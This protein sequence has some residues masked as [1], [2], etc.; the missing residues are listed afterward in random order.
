MQENNSIFD[1]LS[2]FDMFGPQIRLTYFGNTRFST[3]LGGLC[4]IIVYPLIFVLFV[5]SVF[6]SSDE[7]ITTIRRKYTRLDSFAFVGGIANLLF[8]IL[9][10]AF[11]FYNYGL[12]RYGM[13][14]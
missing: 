14:F 9:H 1:K 7:E 3:K 13:Y 10:I 2:S 4:T 5:F 6:I 12:D 11:Y 8:I